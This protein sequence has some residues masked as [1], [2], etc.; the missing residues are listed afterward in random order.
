MDFH[1]NIF[2]NDLYLSNFYAKKAQELNEIEQEFR[3]KNR[4][5]LHPEWKISKR[6]SKCWITLGGIF[7]LNYTMYEYID[8]RG[9]KRRIT[10]YHDDIIKRLKCSKYDFDLIKFCIISDLNN[11]KLPNEL[12]SLKPSKQ[13]L[14]EMKKRFKISQQIFE[15][16][17]KKYNENT[18]VFKQKNYK[19]I[20]I[21]VDDFYTRFQGSKY[22]PKMRIRE[23]ILHQNFIGKNAKKDTKKASAICYFFTKNISEKTLENDSIF[24]KKFINNELKKLE[25]KRKKVVLKGDGARWM[26]LFASDIKVKYSLDYFHL[27]RKINETFGYKKFNSKNH[28]MLYKNW[29]SKVYGARWVD[30]F[31]AIFEKNFNLKYEDFMKLKA[32]FLLEA[33]EKNIEKSFIKQARILFKYI[34]NHCKNIWNNEGNLIIEKSYTEHFVYNFFKKFIKK[35]GSL[36]SRNSIKMKVIYHNLLKNAATF[37]IESDEKNLG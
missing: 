35:Q 22:R 8:A 27:F 13:L 34:N 32:T 21:E 28:K 9:K 24:T 5:I 36:F 15:K 29:F 31:S 18:S 37:F 12:V 23:V 1:I 25:I 20:H 26:S 7:K 3:T 16:N 4:F 6:K 17:D 14:Y 30:L 11:Q 19:K 10:H 33:K 2:N